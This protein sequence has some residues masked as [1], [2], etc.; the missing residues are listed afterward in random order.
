MGMSVAEFSEMR[1]SHFFLK[2][3]YYFKAK[4]VN[5]EQ[6]ANLVRMQTVALINIHLVKKDR[7]RD[8][9]KIW[10]FPWEEQ[11]QKEIK[12]ETEISVKTAIQLSKYL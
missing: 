2:L 11:E 1:L 8:A 6:V 5:I 7:I 9:K 10:A 12:S 4:Q 3:R